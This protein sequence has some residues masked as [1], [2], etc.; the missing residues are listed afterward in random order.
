MLT[1]SAT[2]SDVSTSNS[3]EKGEDVAV[4]SR[5]TDGTCSMYERVCVGGT[6]D[7]LHNGHKQLLLTS[8]LLASHHVT[9]AITSPAMLA[10]K[11]LAPLIQSWEQRKAGVQSF[12]SEI[13]LSRSV[14]I[15]W[16][17]LEEPFGPPSVSP[18]YDC[19]VCSAETLPVGA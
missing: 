7:R 3:L 10:N 6:F 9:V 18:D 2:E 15:E 14:G 13:G 12:L 11:P 16:H 8:A 4:A 1:T 17:T 19:I 5:T